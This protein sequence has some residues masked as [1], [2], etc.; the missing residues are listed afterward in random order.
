MVIFVLKTLPPTLREKKRYISFKIMYP[1][2]LSRNEVVN[3]I[4]NAVIDYYG[5]WGISK[6]NPWLIDYNHPKGLLRINR[7]EVDFVKSALITVKEHKN[8][9]INIVILGVSGSIKKSRI[10]YLKV[11][12]E[13]YYK[14][15]QRIKREKSK[16]SK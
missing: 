7:S 2:I 10:K 15:I 13:E 1:K 5:I 6:S 14:V 8:N 9:P 4:R 12:H 3:L 11:P 16:K